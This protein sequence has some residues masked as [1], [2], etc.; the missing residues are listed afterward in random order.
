MRY[1]KL[2]ILCDQVSHKVEVGPFKQM[3]E[4]LKVTWKYSLTEFWPSIYSFPSDPFCKI[5]TVANSQALL[6]EFDSHDCI[7]TKIHAESWHISR[8][9][10]TA[11][12][13]L[14]S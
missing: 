7:Q 3:I 5:S 1:T 10:S 4:C 14:H 11:C 6:I 2:H 13:V 9:E 12:F 8:D